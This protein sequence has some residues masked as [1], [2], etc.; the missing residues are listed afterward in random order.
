MKTDFLI[1]GQGLAGSLLAWTLIRRGARVRV[2]DDGHRSASSRVAA[3]LV[4]PLAGMRFNAHP[5]TADW[6]AAMHR[7]YA[8][9]AHALRQPGFVHEIPMQRLF[10]SPEQIRFYRRQRD[11]P[12]VADWLGARF[13]PDAADPGIRAPH[14]GF[15]QSHTGY[16]ALPRLLDALRDWLR[17][18]DAWRRQ[19]CDTQALRVHDTEVSLHG[20]QAAEVVFC[21]GWRMRDNPWFDW[22][23]L[24]PD[25]G[26]IQRLEAP[27]P[28][29]RHIVN[30]AHWLIP[31][32]E[33]GY[34]F[35]ATHA[36]QD[37]AGPVRDTERARLA[38]GLHGLI[39]DDSGIRVIEEA[40]GVRPATAD[41]NA[42]LGPHPQQA[43]LHLFNG[44]GARGALSIPWYAERM[45]DWLLDRRPL[46]AE[47]DI[48][49]HV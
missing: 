14:G 23:P 3:G 49:R 45:A 35:G 20:E 17:G 28:L 6:L 16:V 47:A 29:C 31:L 33:D 32:A 21:E 22:L 27:R 37:L 10:R 46:P 30:G 19:P 48:A 13:D 34:R 15:V 42:F 7:L 36:H 4:N 9:I 12:A 26:V 11:N 43:R 25:R 40:A 38:E 1:V 39:E 2:L 5:R 8:A 18:Q 44:F 24:Q 41:R